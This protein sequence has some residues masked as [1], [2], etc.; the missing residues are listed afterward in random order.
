MSLTQS[1]LSV[2]NNWQYTVSDNSI[3][4][5]L[6]KNFWYKCESYISPKISP[7]LISFTGFF[8]ILSNFIITY[9]FHDFYPLLTELY[10]IISTQI[11]CHLDAIDGIH[12]RNTKTSSPLG[13]LVDHICDTVGLIFI[14]LTFAF[15]FDIT[16][17]NTLTYTTI[18]GILGFQFFHIQAYFYKQ[19][20]FGKYTGPVEILT[21]YC[22]L[23]FM[24]MCNLIDASNFKIMNTLSPYILFFCLM[25]NI[26]Y[27]INYINHY[28]DVV[29]N[30]I[31]DTIYLITIFSIYNI[32]NNYD[33]YY[34]FNICLNLCVLTCDFII[35]KMASKSLNK[36]CLQVFI[37]SRFSN[38]LGIVLSIYYICA[39]LNEIA[40]YMKLNIIYHNLR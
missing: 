5:K 21:V 16:N 37:F 32:S 4:T 10:V 33:M 1:Q 40:K 3:T 30:I 11:Y 26:Y 12:A 35:S 17:I 29:N 20:E 15:I 13:E 36:M 14:I 23:I 2:I 39:S 25:F 18:T 24:K 7:N 8:L 27:M 9:F 6:Y 22:V 28:L 19:V 31:F 38:I 34:L